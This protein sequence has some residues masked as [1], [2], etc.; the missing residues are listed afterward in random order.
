MVRADQ[1]PGCKHLVEVIA[2]DERSESSLGRRSGLPDA[3]RG[4]DETRRPRT[5]VSFQRQP[6]GATGSVA[7]SRHFGAS[8]PIGYVVTALPIPIEVAD[9]LHLPGG[10]DSIMRDRAFHFDVQAIIS[11]T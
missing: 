9:A 4:A 11:Q 1:G 8:P 3:R 6:R 7:S 5:S 2:A 10:G